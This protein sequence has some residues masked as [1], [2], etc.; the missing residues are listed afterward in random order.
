MTSKSASPIKML[1]ILH[2]FTPSGRFFP[3]AIFMHK[4]I[5]K[6]TY[7]PQ[8]RSLSGLSELNKNY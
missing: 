7:P 5:L 2:L 4:S 3:S 6:A 8:E 1:T